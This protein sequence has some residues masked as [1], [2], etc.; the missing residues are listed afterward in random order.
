M[1]AR[2]YEGAMDAWKEEL[3][4]KRAKRFRLSGPDLEDALQDTAMEM[5]AFRFDPAKDAGGGERAALTSVID[6]RLK[7]F[8]RDKA[9]YKTLVERHS[10]ELRK[11]AYEENLDLR[12]MILEAKATLSAF[13]IQVCEGL[14]SGMSLSQIGE[15][16]DCAWSTVRKAVQR[17]RAAFEEHGLNP[18]KS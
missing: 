5:L 17:I 12:K 7:M 9:K 3:L 1:A 2:R 15:E 10:L 11:D 14:E 16:A 18:S 8:I 6:N 13:D 4:V